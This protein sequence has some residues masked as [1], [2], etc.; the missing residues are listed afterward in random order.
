MWRSFYIISN[1]AIPKIIQL[2]I[3]F[4]GWYTHIPQ[5]YIYIHMCV[6]RGTFA[7]P[8]TVKQLA[9]EDGIGVKIQLEPQTK[10]RSNSPLVA[11]NN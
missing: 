8:H 2:E 4:W 7:D 1:R 9:K 6:Y 11:H 10:G 5:L 3:Y